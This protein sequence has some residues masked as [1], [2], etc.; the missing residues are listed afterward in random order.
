MI[1]RSVAVIAARKSAT[2][3]GPAGSRVGDGLDAADGEIETSGDI[4]DGES[5][6]VAPELALLQ[7]ASKTSAPMKRLISVLPLTNGRQSRPGEG[8]LCVW[9]D[10]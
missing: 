10:A 4:T 1:G 3:T 5:A 6:L 8:R 7:L 2:F 9:C